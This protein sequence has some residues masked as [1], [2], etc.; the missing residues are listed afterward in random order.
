M[1][2]CLQ[3]YLSSGL[4][5][6]KFVNLKIRQ[7][8]AETC[9]DFIEWCGLINGSS[10]N[11]KLQ[12]DFRIHIQDCYNSFTEEYPDYAP[13]AKMS[14]SRVRFNKWMTA[15]ARYKTGANPEEGRDARGRWMRLKR[16]DEVNIQKKLL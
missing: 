8:S 15:Y 3:D 6:S 11:N 2:K 14:L 10:S 16:E 12:I 13:R 1:I 5:E 7:L 4:V 9:H